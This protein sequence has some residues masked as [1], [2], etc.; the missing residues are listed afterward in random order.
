MNHLLGST[1]TKIEP[2]PRG[3]SVSRT[4]EK[5][6]KMRTN[7]PEALDSSWIQAKLESS[8]SGWQP[9]SYKTGSETC[10]LGCWAQDTADL[11]G[12]PASSSLLPLPPERDSERGYYEVWMGVCSR[13][14]PPLPQ[15][16]VVFPEEPGLHLDCKTSLLST[17]DCWKLLRF[18]RCPR[19]TG[20]NKFWRERSCSP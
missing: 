4:P 12:H 1:M 19:G 3:A 9:A 16:S 10:V 14:L 7:I 20:K 18:P 6:M 5:Q 2:S 15:C 11:S 17:S 13:F 8:E